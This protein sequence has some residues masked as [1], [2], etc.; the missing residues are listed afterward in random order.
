MVTV[1]FSI[2]PHLAAYMY[3]RFKNHIHSAIHLPDTHPIYHFLHQLSVPH[4]PNVSWR[5]TGNIT[6]SLPH[7]RNGKNPYVYNYIGHD[8]AL[9]IEKEIEVEMKA[10]LYEF[11]LENKYCHGIMFKKSMGIFV[12]HYNMVE[13]VEEESLMR[14][15]QRWRKAIKEGSGLNRASAGLTGKLT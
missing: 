13:L 12:E 6:F 14:M 3:V 15:F 2:K 7:P 11:L 4:P 5:E 9:I 8:S 1:T 10:E